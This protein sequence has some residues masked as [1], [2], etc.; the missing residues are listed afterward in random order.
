MSDVINAIYQYLQHNA[1]IVQIALIFIIS[2]V[3]V[4]IEGMVYRRLYPRL[5]KTQHIW[6][7]SFL[8]AVH[9]PLVMFIW[10]IGASLLIPVLLE[11]LDLATSSIKY[12]SQARELL[13]VIACL[14]FLMRYIHN[15]EQRLSARAPTGKHKMRD[16]TTIRAIAQL[17]RIFVVMLAILIS[18]QTLGISIATLLAAGGVGG[19]AVGWAAKDTL[20]NFIGGMMIYWDRPFSVGDWIRSPDRNIEGTVEQI[21]WRLT[22]IRTFDKRPLY[23]PN[24]IFSSISVENPSRMSN[25][26]IKTTIGLRYDDA[27]KVAVILHD[28]ETMLRNHPE[29]DTSQTLMVNLTEFADSSLNFLLY[30]FTKTTV[31]TQYLA[32]QQDVFL[33]II[34][35]ID[36]HGAECAFPTTTLH[37]PE[38]LIVQQAQGESV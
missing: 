34:D 36:Q 11:K 37:V 7:D 14:W 26:R 38:G 10:L 35:I 22:R 20:A 17:I 8:D 2:S 24:G 31:W 25:R 30:T 9:R 12:F 15:I 28:I 3:L 18:L 4:F 16:K 5:A 21:G 27:T 33:K 29:I 1:W 19:L 23:V 13:F 32:V 6:D